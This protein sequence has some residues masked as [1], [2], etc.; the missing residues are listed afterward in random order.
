MGAAWWWEA[1]KLTEC[2][3]EASS[4]D[5]RFDQSVY[6]QGGVLTLHQKEKFG[7]RVPKVREDCESDQMG[8]FEPMFLINPTC[9]TIV[10]RGINM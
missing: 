4:R 7:V 6:N 8:K 9:Q 2:R 1:Q 5:G 3:F 10:E